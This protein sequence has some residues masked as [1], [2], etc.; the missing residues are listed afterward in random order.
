MDW[1]Y[2]ELGA[3]FIYGVDFS[4]RFI[5]GRVIFCANAVLTLEWRESN[6][7]FVGHNLCRIDRVTLRSNMH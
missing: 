7:P 4:S 3:R 5:N 1:L 2:G 6:Q